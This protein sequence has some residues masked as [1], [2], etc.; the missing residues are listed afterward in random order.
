MLDYTNL[1]N[2]ANPANADG[3]VWRTLDYLAHLEAKITNILDYSNCK[4]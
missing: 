3:E 1:A 4:K 2:R